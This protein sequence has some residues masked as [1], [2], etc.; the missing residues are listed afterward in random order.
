V[1]SVWLKVQEQVGIITV[2]SPDVRNALTPEMGDQMVEVC[3]AVDSD[4]AIGAVVVR[5]AQGSFCSGAD[6]RAWA[7]DWDP[8]DPETYAQASRIYAA[9]LRV[10][11][12]RCP[13]VAAVRGAAV[14]AGMNLAMACDLRVMGE[15][16]W[17]IAGFA[18]VGLHPGGGFFSVLGRTAGR[19]A[20][21][22]MGIFNERITGRRAVELG[23]AW[24]ALDDDQVEARAVE[25]AATA[26]RDPQLA[27]QIVR[28]FRAEM[29]PPALPWPVALEFERGTQMWSQKRYQQSKK[30]KDGA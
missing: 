16:A 17:L 28:S 29:G 2:D 25:L 14:G 22:A 5:G 23:I 24:Q 12:L 15:E 9:F 10:G 1:G 18:G 6:T 11:E 4:P 21:A 30:T 13:T 8:A 3:D 7:Q 26:G 19:E 20:T 27:R